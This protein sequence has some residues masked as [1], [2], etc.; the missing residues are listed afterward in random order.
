MNSKFEK[1][2]SLYLCV[3]SCLG[4][5]SDHLSLDE[6][7]ATGD[8]RRVC[9]MLDRLDES[10]LLSLA[11]NIGRPGSSGAYVC[12]EYCAQ[13]LQDIQRF[14]RTDTSS[15]RH[16]ANQLIT[17]NFVSKDI[18]P[19]IKSQPDNSEL[20]FH[21]LKVLVFLTFPV[22]EGPESTPNHK[23]VLAAV[24]T[25]LD[26]FEAVQVI[27][28]LVCDA[29]TRLEAN[30][31]NK[32]S[33]INELEL[34]L[35]LFRNITV[36]CI[37][38]EADQDGQSSAREELY[39]EWVFK[40]H[41]D[42]LIILISQDL[43]LPQLSTI[44]FLI[45]EAMG[46]LCNGMKGRESE[47]GESCRPMISNRT[48]NSVRPWTKQP[49]SVQ[50]FY[51]KYQHDAIS[52]QCAKSF[53]I[54]KYQV[55]NVSKRDTARVKNPSFLSFVE[56]F[57]QLALQSVLSFALKKV[58]YN[59]DYQTQESVIRIRNILAI[60]TLFMRMST[61]KEHGACFCK[62]YTNVHFACMFTKSFVRWF[63]T[64]WKKFDD[65]NHTAPCTILYEFSA[66][67][68]NF[69]YANVQ[70]GSQGLMIAAQAC[71]KQMFHDKHETPITAHLLRR[72]RNS[73][74]KNVSQTTLLFENLF[75]ASRLYKCLRD[76]N[77]SKV[78]VHVD[79]EIMKRF[80]NCI[81]QD[82][83]EMN[84]EVLIFYLSILERDNKPFQNFDMLVAYASFMRQSHADD[85]K[86]HVTTQLSVLIN[87]MLNNSIKV[88]N[89]GSTYLR[90]LISQNTRILV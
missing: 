12:D 30:C 64:L 73:D 35:T 75:Y 11:S 61:C 4:F 18:I 67:F 60:L 89:L 7:S 19:L 50:R 83:H 56:R 57:E 39:L 74:M 10:H 49:P 47:D 22:E 42:E 20:V 65:K 78:G 32:L 46:C 9:T 86:A 90:V 3:C 29:F 82:R 58:D 81:T 8:T 31:G 80:I 34:V 88:N 62:S 13:A 37:N 1:I 25:I 21:A 76:G 44:G 52:G 43:E 48:G 27:L 68:M 17:W 26:N 40:C 14:L 38:T 33:Q 23:K 87:D 5:G 77:E 85:Y 79:S 84:R 24:D 16:A 53:I 63:N 69:M 54:G 28:S 55:R 2:A 71:A 41:F 66:L 15:Q 6:N 72:L 70:S 59:D 51:G 45:L 36:A